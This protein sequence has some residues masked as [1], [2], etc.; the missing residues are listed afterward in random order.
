MDARPERPKG[1]ARISTCLFHPNSRQRMT[2]N[3]FNLRKGR[4][5]YVRAHP[6]A[7]ACT[8]RS[9][10][11]WNSNMVFMLFCL[12]YLWVSI[13]SILSAICSALS[14]SQIKLKGGYFAHKQQQGFSPPVSNEGELMLQFQKLFPPPCSHRGSW[15]SCPPCVVCGTCYPSNESRKDSSYSRV[16]FPSRL[17]D[18]R[19][20]SRG[21]GGFTAF[22]INPVCIFIDK[23]YSTGNSAPVI[24]HGGCASKQGLTIYPCAWWLLI[25][26]VSSGPH[27]SAFIWCSGHV[28]S[29]YCIRCDN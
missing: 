22:V 12:F 2:E 28:I 20:D 8:L 5:T 19:A 11:F 29:H 6:K 27:L 21:N 23:G 13:S 10:W 15:T 17:F 18:S 7:D 25:N 16:D 24:S 26:S 1:G 14:S 4:R 3:P 9:T